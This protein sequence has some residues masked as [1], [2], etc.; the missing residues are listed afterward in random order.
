MCIRD[1]S[2]H[3]WLSTFRPSAASTAAAS[4]RAPSADCAF[5]AVV[6]LSESTCAWCSFSTISVSLR[7]VEP[8]GGGQRG[9]WR[10]EN[11]HRFLINF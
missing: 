1:R 6:T 4:S 7:A 9:E 2:R 10:A 5:F 11:S 3:S 8:G